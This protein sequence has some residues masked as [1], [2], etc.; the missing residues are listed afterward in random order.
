MGIPPCLE[1]FRAFYNCRF[2]GKKKMEEEEGGEEGYD[3]DDEEEEEEEER[4]KKRAKGKNSSG[5][6]GCCHFRLRDGL[7]K[8]YIHVSLRSNFKDWRHQWLYFGDESGLKYSLPAAPP[9]DLG[10]W[11]EEALYSAVVRNLKAR[12]LTLKQRGLTRAVVLTDTVWLCI[13]PMRRPARLA[14]M[15]LGVHDKQRTFHEG[16]A[17]LITVLFCLICGVLFFL[18]FNFPLFF[19][20]ECACR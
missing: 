20:L 19:S 16:K 2:K 13:S 4:K 7:R 11:K 3:D 5:A 10:T 8:D 6:F 9:R 1:L 15:Y 17:P 12:I 14:C 18:S